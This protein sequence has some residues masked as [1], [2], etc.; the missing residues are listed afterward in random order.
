MFQTFIGDVHEYFEA[1]P[2]DGM[3]A[4]FSYACHLSK[5]WVES[6]MEDQLGRLPHPEEVA[7]ILKGGNYPEKLIP[8]ITRSRE[9]AHEYVEEV[10]GSQRAQN[11]PLCPLSMKFLHRMADARSMYAVMEHRR[12]FAKEYTELALS[13]AHLPQHKMDPDTFPIHIARRIAEMDNQLANDFL[14]RLAIVEADLFLSDP[15]PDGADLIGVYYR[16][17][18]E[19]IKPLDILAEAPYLQD[20]FVHQVHK[21]V[22][23][24]PQQIIPM[25]AVTQGK[26]LNLFNSNLPNI[27]L[28][29]LHSDWKTFTAINFV[30]WS[31]T[32]K[33][34]A[35]DGQIHPLQT[36]QW[37]PNM[38]VK[39]DDVTHWEAA[40]INTM[41]P[42][43]H[44]PLDDVC[45]R[46]HQAVQKKNS[47]FLG[48]LGF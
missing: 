23:E 24:N 44:S 22:K 35:L 41:A 12:M 20:L 48:R 43:G 17:E 16:S 15:R 33:E 3:A 29:R 14:T 11:D 8:L 5:R 30:N 18:A 47:S 7:E 4:A 34:P 36:A 21:A 6:Q 32:H 37:K 39:A 2:Q 26:I 46:L 19:N 28:S 27:D 13:L 45:S 31:Q 9:P 10:Y 25:M 40:R 38:S 1:H 42:S